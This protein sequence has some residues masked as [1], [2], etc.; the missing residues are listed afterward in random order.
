LCHQDKTLKEFY[1]SVENLK[2]LGYI[3]IENEKTI[4]TE[5]GKNFL[6]KEIGEREAFDAKCSPCEGKGYVACNPT[7]LEKYKKVLEK[8]PPPKEDYD[9]TSIS[10]EDAII[11]VAFFHERGDLL[12]KELLFIGDFD[13]LSIVAAMTR[14][15]KRIVVLDV[16]ERLINYINQV[17]VDLNLTN[18]LSAKTFDVRVPLPEEF[19]RSFDLFSCDPVETL[20]G[21]TL[22]L[23]RGTSGLKG[24]GSVCYVGLTTLEASRKKW[25]DIQKVLAD[26]NFVFTDVRRNFNGYPDTGLEEKHII[27]EK[28]GCVPKCV[29]YWAAVLRCE[30]IDEPKPIVTGR[31]DR[32]DIYVDDE[33]WATPILDK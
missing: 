30:L 11:R 2:K 31:Y 15:P 17:A 9:Q 6:T 33:A 7:F 8:R 18:I 16:D 23:S 29:W 22:Y 14:L 3:K 19:H 27:Y 4:L 1:E 26:M 28:L 32:E 25:F 24:V 10:A 20:D 21:I 12:Q 13:C 5:E